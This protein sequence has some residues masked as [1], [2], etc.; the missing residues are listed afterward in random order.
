MKKY[1][2]IPNTKE[3]CEKYNAE[4]KCTLDNLGYPKIKVEYEK[5]TKSKML[6]LSG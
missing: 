4:G 3:K 5:N 1:G 2:Y 6:Y